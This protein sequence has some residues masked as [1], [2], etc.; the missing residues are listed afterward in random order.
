MTD[1]ETIRFEEL[2]KSEAVCDGFDLTITVMLMV[3]DRDDTIG[4][5]T[6]QISSN[7]KLNGRVERC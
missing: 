6:N 1:K 4:F 7:G 2:T 3:K 5:F